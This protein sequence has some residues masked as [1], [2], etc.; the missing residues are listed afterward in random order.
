MFRKSWVE[1]FAKEIEHQECTLGVSSLKIEEFR[2]SLEDN[3][4]SFLEKTTWS[5]TQEFLWGLTY[6]LKQFDKS[7]KMDL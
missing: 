7:C 3:F 5:F 2:G 1:I 6:N 4:K